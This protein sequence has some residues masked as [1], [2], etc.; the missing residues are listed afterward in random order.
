[1]PCLVAQRNRLALGE[2][3]QFRWQRGRRRHRRT[4]DQHRDH[5]VT[6]D[7]CGCELST[8]VVVGIGESMLSVRS[9]GHKPA[10][11]NDGQGDITLIEGS[12]DG[13]VEVFAGTD[14]HHIL[15]HPVGPKRAASASRRR[16]AQ[17]DES[18]RR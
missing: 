7:E 17:A 12:L 2:R 8:H 6:V 1:M 5:L 11:S 15:K 10:W 4:P 3:A 18:S 9:R 14:G 16:P 13:V